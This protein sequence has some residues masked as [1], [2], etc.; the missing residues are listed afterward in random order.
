MGSN[1]LGRNNGE[2]LA[3]NPFNPKQLYMGTRFDGLWVSNDRAQTWT[4][5]T[6]FPNAAANGMGLYFVL[7]DPSHN[8]TIYVGASVPGGLYY[9][10]NGGSTWAQVPNQPMDWSESPIYAAV[11]PGSTGPQP[12]KGVLGSNGILYVTYADVSC[13]FEQHDCRACLILS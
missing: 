7:F 11:A 1:D 13:T 12:A 8:G 2:R 3:V 10:K 9:T 4:N 6:N 5:V